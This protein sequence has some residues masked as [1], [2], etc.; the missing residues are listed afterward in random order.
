MKY[1]QE[2]GLFGLSVLTLHKPFSLDVGVV[3]DDLHGLYLGV[4][5]TMLDLWFSKQYKGKAFYIGD[6][7][8]T[9]LYMYSPACHYTYKLES[10]TAY[11]CYICLQQID[12][13]DRRLLSIRV[14][15][16]VSRL[17][18]TLSDHSRW[19]GSYDN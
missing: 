1:V 2:K 3:V 5:E 16:I 7:V 4:S 10:I 19:K 17:P 14:P 6:K 13:C 15:D 18:K 8:Y 12:E 9:C 11:L